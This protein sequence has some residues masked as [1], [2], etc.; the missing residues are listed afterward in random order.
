[1]GGVDTAIGEE[2]ADL[3]VGGG[4]FAQLLGEAENQRLTLP[5]EP[6]L[7][8][9]TLTVDLPIQL[10]ELCRRA[11]VIEHIQLEADLR[12]SDAVGAS[13]HP[14]PHQGPSL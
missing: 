6:K 12:R 14:D 4:R 1:M 7:L 8:V 5:D 10:A 3:L 2:V 9:Q 13:L 11:V